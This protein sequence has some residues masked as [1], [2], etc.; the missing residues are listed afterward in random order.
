MD[1]DLGFAQV[2]EYSLGWAGDPRQCF[3]SWIYGANRKGEKEDWMTIFFA[4]IWSLWKH[5][6]AAVFKKEKVNI[7][8]LEQDVSCMVLVW[9][10]DRRLRR[11]DLLQMLSSISRHSNFIEHT[12]EKSKQANDIQLRNPV[13]I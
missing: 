11:T 3:E 7:S 6:N 9:S 2:F 12:S 8:L 10:R 4:I 13:D 5:R 1:W